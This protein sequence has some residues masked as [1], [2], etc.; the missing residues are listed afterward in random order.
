MFI[1]DNEVFVVLMR[2]FFVHSLCFFV[3]SLCVCAVCFCVHSVFVQYNLFTKTSLPN[4]KCPFQDVVITWPKSTN[5][6]WKLPM[7]FI[8]GIMMW[9]KQSINNWIFHQ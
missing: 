1:W 7:G 8:I 5:H 6:Q 2:V 3:H 9:H 4:L